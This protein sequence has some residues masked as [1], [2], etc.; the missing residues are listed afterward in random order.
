MNTIREM[1]SG[2][3]KVLSS[4]RVMGALVLCA[5]MYCIIYLVLN[6]GG[7]QIV[8][9]LLQTA[10]L[11]AGGLLGVSTISGIWRKSTSTQQATQEEPKPIDPCEGCPHNKKGTD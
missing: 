8:E 1:L 9:N 4:K 10:I 3:N 7:T 2:E 11:T 5:C 6:E